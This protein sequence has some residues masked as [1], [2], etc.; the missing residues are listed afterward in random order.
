MKIL[1]TNNYSLFV[2]ASFNRDVR[3]NRWLRESLLKFGWIPTRPL[4]VRRRHDGKLE[5][6]DGHHRYLLACELKIDIYYGIVTDEATIPDLTVTERPWSVWDSL[7]GHLRT[8]KHAY[9]ALNSYQKRTGI[10]LSSCIGLMSGQM[11]GTSSNKLQQFKE[12]TYA[13]GDMTLADMVGDIIILCQAAGVSFARN[14]YFVQAVSKIC[15]AAD[16]D[17]KMMMKK[18]SKFSEFMVKQPSKQHYVKMLDEVYNRSSQAKV[19][20]EF[21]AN[22]A[23]RQRSAI[24]S[25]PPDLKQKVARRGWLGKVRKAA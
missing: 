6:R 10:P 11:S 25:L 12:G 24:Q 14:N 2:L 22:E 19:P 13:V 3:R 1:S 7:C 16:F 18:I 5:I 15:L 4:E 23:S 9:M 17:P 20:L 21:Q 8:G